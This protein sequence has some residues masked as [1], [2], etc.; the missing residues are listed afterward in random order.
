MAGNMSP[1]K[2][3]QWSRPVWTMQSQDDRQPMTSFSY[4]NDTI[5]KIRR[6]SSLLILVRLALVAV[7]IFISIYLAGC[8]VDDKVFPPFAILFLRACIAGPWKPLIFFIASGPSMISP[9]K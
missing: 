6:P 3:S 1:A 5:A 4:R 7:D 2:I 9:N 8:C